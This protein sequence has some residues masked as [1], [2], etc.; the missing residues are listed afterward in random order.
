MVDN[1]EKSTVTL[2]PGSWN[3]EEY[4]CVRHAPF[5]DIGMTAEYQCLLIRLDDD[6]RSDPM[7]CYID[8]EDY[9]ATD[10]IELTRLSEWLGASD[11][12]GD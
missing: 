3:F 12:A 10:G 2:R 9:R 4:E 5:V 8:H 6:N 1:E 11:P 7:V